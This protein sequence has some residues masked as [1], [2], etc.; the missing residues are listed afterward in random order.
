MVYV[1]SEETINPGSV[2]AN[3]NPNQSFFYFQDPPGAVTL[4]DSDKYTCNLPA[5]NYHN[6]L[7]HNFSRCRR[8]CQCRATGDRRQER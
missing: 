7:Y 6:A 3:M 1:L 5:R 2:H 8:P 4:S